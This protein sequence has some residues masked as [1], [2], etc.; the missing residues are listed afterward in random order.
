MAL[1][2]DLSCTQVMEKAAECAV[3]V[4]T[5]DLENPAESMRVQSW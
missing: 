1:R 2:T 3:A 4:S 5:T